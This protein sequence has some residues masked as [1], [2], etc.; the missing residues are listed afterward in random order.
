MSFIDS[1]YTILNYQ[2]LNCIEAI[3][4]EKYFVNFKIQ[5]NDGDPSPQHQ[6]NYITGL[7]NGDGFTNYTGFSDYYLITTKKID[8]A[9]L[10]TNFNPLRVFYSHNGIEN[11]LEIVIDR[12]QTIIAE[13]DTLPPET[14]IYANKYHD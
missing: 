4:Y 13:L 6:F 10:T 8:N 1:N 5:T 9:G 11:S 12:N 7:Q 3:L 14:R 2:N